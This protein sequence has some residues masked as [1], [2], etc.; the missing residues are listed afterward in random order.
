[1]L[2]KARIFTYGYN[3]GIAFTGSASKIDDYARTLLE[4]LRAKRREFDPDVTRPILFI[5]H[6]LGGI[7]FK[8]AMII[9]H[10]RS[11]RYWAISR[12][13]YG[14]LFMGTPHRGSDMAFWTTV[15]GKIAD[16]FTLGS[17]RTQLLQDLQPKS[18][19]LGT[20]CSQFVER[21]QSLR[22]FTFYERL[23]ISGMPELVR[24]SCEKPNVLLKDVG[25]G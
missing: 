20:I 2:P 6:S 5:C 21:A 19:C 14:V 16:V 22:I 10:E 25:C 15:I 18:A 3:S 1:M 23:K 11:E 7:V 8:K 9:A 4:R 13:T 24:L 17:I 12:D